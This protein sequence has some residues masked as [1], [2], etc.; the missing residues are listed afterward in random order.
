MT[1]T[2]RPAESPTKARYLTEEYE[3]FEDGRSYMC[4]KVEYL[5]EVYEVCRRVQKPGEPA[6]E[7]TPHAFIKPGDRGYDELV[8]YLDQFLEPHEDSHAE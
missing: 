2:E 6:D 8:T 5:G 3:V 7:I 1:T 4:Q